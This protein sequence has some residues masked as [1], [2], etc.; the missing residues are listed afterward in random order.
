MRV[1]TKAISL[2]CNFRPSIISQP[3]PAYNYSTKAGHFIKNQN[4]VWASKR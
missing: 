4:S 1:I 3:G 2:Y